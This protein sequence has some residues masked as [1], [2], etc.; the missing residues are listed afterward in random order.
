M[1]AAASQA[2]TRMDNVI[3]MM[4]GIGLTLVAA[5]LPWELF[6]RIPGTDLTLVK[7][8]SATTIAAAILSWSRSMGTTFPRTGLLPCISVIALAALASAIRSHD[9]DATRALLTVYAGY[10]LFFFAMATFNRT[11]SAA[12]RLAVLYVISAVCVAAI[13]LIAYAG[14]M[15]PAHWDTAFWP[16]QRLLHEFR[17][18]QPMRI[19]GANIDFNQASLHIFIALAIVLFLPHDSRRGRMIQIVVGFVL[20]AAIAVGMSR[21]GVLVSVCLVFAAGVR[22]THGRPRI[23]MIALLVLGLGAVPFLFGDFASM[24]AMR[25]QGGIV[26]D[27]GSAENRIDVYRIAL[28]M[29]PQY[30]LLGAGLG[31][32]EAAMRSSAYEGGA[33]MA[34]HS[35]PLL[36]LVELG[37]IGLFAYLWLWF[38]VFR[39]GVFSLVK[40]DDASRFGAA[41]GAV[42]SST[43]AML[44]VQ[45][46][47]MLPLYPFVLGLGFGPVARRRDIEQKRERP[48][49]TYGLA[50]AVVLA[51]TLVAAENVLQFQ[52]TASAA[53]RYADLLESGLAFEEAGAWASAIPQYAQ[54]AELAHNNL[55]Q[56]PYFS[57]VNALI[58]LQPLYHRFG[59][60]GT[61][62]PEAVGWFALGRALLAD[63]GLGDAEAVLS[64][65]WSLDSQFTFIQFH[66]AEAN[67]DRARFA[68][69]LDHYKAFAAMPADDG[70]PAYRIRQ[71]TSLSH[72]ETDLTGINAQ[73]C[74]LQAARR[75][76]Q[77]NESLVAASDALK[78]DPSCAEAH[79]ILGVGAERVGF[80]PDD[81]YRAA[82]S[83]LPSHRLAR[84]ALNRVATQGN[85]ED[86]SL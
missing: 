52:K 72:C 38:R 54:A 76:G 41:Y 59:A 39:N 22:N 34:I 4:G 42:T 5:A 1:T 32:S 11:P 75:N 61:T 15:W 82:L 16:D 14:L 58:D 67:W 20:F 62:T 7:V 17:D 74:R 53:E 86:D 70:S 46:F 65:A 9:P 60:M 33:V 27:E 55:G 85:K 57:E 47:M 81:H 45:P 25:A 12:S 28:K 71:S 56:R 2:P 50:S 21:S 26:Y 23:A 63:G 80:L 69:S 68:K 37:L 51:T 24:F 3:R 13:T 10:A 40:R 29:V 77:W 49:I 8:G 84:V 18:G 30:A 66:L 79:F 6:Q 64:A 36:L 48:S 44:L 73:L 78:I 43:F 35:M 83:A 31:A 19:T